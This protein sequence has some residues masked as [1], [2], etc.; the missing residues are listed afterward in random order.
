[1]FWCVESIFFQRWFSQCLCFGNLALWPS[2]TFIQLHHQRKDKCL[3]TTWEYLCQVRV[4]ILPTQTGTKCL[5]VSINLRV[6]QYLTM[7]T[8][9]FSGKKFNSGICRLDSPKG[10]QIN[11]SN[12]K[13]LSR[14]CHINLV[15]SGT[16]NNQKYQKYS[17]NMY[18]VNPQKVE[19]S[20]T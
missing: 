10:T 16:I 1:M 6:T 8:A 15:N 18:Q 13:P 14:G 4:Q 3:E 17:C 9:R 20:N 12:G 7:Q 5:R 2:A 11:L 19:I